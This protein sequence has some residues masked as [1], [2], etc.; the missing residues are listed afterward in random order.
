MSQQEINTII[1]AIETHLETLQAKP[2]KVEAKAWAK[3]YKALSSELEMLK[4]SDPKRKHLSD[5][6]EDEDN[7]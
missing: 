2:T 1:R 3:K 4:A 6:D 7:D 5:D